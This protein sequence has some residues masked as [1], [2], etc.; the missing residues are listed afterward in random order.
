MSEPTES[1]EAPQSTPR[2]KPYSPPR[3][4]EYGPVE[5]LTHSGTG[6]VGDGGPMMMPACL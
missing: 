3:L 2:R 5:K 6:T 1:A 4:V